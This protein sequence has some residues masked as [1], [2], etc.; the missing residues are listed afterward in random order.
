MTQRAAHDQKNPGIGHSAIFPG[1]GPHDPSAPHVRHATVRVD[2]SSAGV[3]IPPIWASIG[4]D[5]INWTYTPTGRRLLK[6]IGEFSSAPFHVRPH[7]IFVSGSGFGLPHWGSGNVYH[8]DEE[9]APFYD[10]SIADETYDTIVAAGHHVLVELGFTPRALVPEHAYEELTVTDSPSV[11]SAYEAGHWAYPPKDYSKWADAVAALAQHCLQ[12]YGANE[13]SQWLWE[14]WNEPDIFYWRGTRQ[15]FARLYEVTVTAVRSVLPTARVGGPAVTAGENGVGFLRDFLAHADRRELPVDFVS[16]HT[17]GSCFAPWRSYG[18]IGDGAVEKQSPM[19]TKMLHEIR[20]LLRVMA[21]FPRY[22]AAPAIVDECDAGV[23]AHLGIY[24]NPNFRFQNTEY[25]PVFQVNLMK[26]ILDLNQ[27]EAASVAEATSWTFYFEG[28]RYFEGTRAFVTAGGIEKPFLN[29]YRVLARLGETRIEAASSASWS[30]A[31]LDATVPASP[32][33]EVDAL[34]TRA[35]NG[36]IS[37]VVYRHTDDQYQE[38]TESAQVGITVSGLS[39]PSYLVTHFR[40]DRTHS[41]A[42]TVWKDLG[43]PQD[44]STDQLAAIRARQGLEL[45]EAERIVTTEDGGV[46]LALELPL[47]SMSLLLLAPRGQEL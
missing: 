9:G 24:D 15:E 26:K 21:E 41:N 37:I 20:T 8:E 25:Y 44:P 30:V 47:E 7:N 45:F 42:H 2:A 28:E 12:R 1:A 17:K 36:E 35:G 34:A 38:D 33:E 18:P 4:Y 5:E 40:I 13:V 3:P 11:Y 32:P 6:T 16:F 22:A 10:F 29:A 14:L 39:A 19:T 43:C 27:M 23:P 31:D 46:T